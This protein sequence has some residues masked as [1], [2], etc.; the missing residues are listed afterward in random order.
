MINL[1]SKFYEEMLQKE[2][3]MGKKGSN[4]NRQIFKCASY[5]TLYTTRGGILGEKNYFIFLSEDN[6]SNNK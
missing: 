6:F 2:E 1:I 5:Y 3:A 4:I